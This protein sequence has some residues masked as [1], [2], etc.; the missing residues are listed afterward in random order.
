M[1][2]FLA[3]LFGRHDNRP[4]PDTE[5]QSVTQAL[6]S[7]G[8]A[9]IAPDVL[10]LADRSIRIVELPARPGEDFRGHSRLGGQPDLVR[11]GA[12]PAWKGV[13][14]A[15]V[16][17]LRLEELAA[18]DTARRLPASGL[19][20][21]FYDSRQET[22]GADPGDRGGW[23]VSY[24]G[25]DPAEWQPLP[26]PADLPAESRY[27]PAAVSFRGELTLPS[28]PRQVDPALAWSDEEVQRYEDWLA[29]RESPAERATPHH[30]ILGYPDQIQDDMQMESA[31][32]ANG[33]HSLNDSGAAAAAQSKADW[34]LLL[35]VDSDA[36]LGMRWGSAGMIYYWIEAAALKDARFERTWLVLQSD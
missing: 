35:Q 12:W 10:R 21:F 31:L 4:Q 24:S 15:F 9:R 7:A 19:L 34:R 3:R 18:F 20:S 36:N 32:A 1:D 6:S 22:Y 11:G 28:A 13:S 25:G 16:G 5:R 29:G 30:R 14:M 8:L 33:F 23:Q 17:Q 2:R 26:F 27:K